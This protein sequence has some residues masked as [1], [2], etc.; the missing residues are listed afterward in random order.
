MQSTSPS[1]AASA[2]SRARGAGPPRTVNHSG[3]PNGSEQYCNPQWWTDPVDLPQRRRRQPATLWHCFASHTGSCPFL[4]LHQCRVPDGITSITGSGIAGHLRPCLCL[5]LHCGSATAWVLPT[6]STTAVSHPTAKSSTGCDTAV[7]AAV[8]NSST[9]RSA[10]HF[11]GTNHCCASAASTPGSRSADSCCPPAHRTTSSHPADTTAL[12]NSP[13]DLPA[14]TCAY[15]PRGPSPTAGKKDLTGAAGSAC[16][17]HPATGRP[18]PSSTTHL[19]PPATHKPDLPTDQCGAS[20]PD[21]TAPRYSSSAPDFPGGSEPGAPAAQPVTGYTAP[22]WVFT[23]TTDGSSSEL[24][25]TPNHWYV[26]LNGGCK[27]KCK[28]YSLGILCLVYLA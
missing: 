15:F 16:H 26:L 14:S 1:T 7:P 17:P 25:V 18:T 28:S 20:A 2:A 11:P 22:E 21:V 6:T 9:V 23:V 3:Q 10:G 12:C 19:G 4:R 5:D 8:S 24:R 27:R 13:T